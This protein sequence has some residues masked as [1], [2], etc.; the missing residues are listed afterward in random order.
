[1]Q[2]IIT[3]LMVATICISMVAA[4]LPLSTI[5]AAAS[6]EFTATYRSGDHVKLEWA[7]QMAD[8]DV[9]TQSGFE[10]QSEFSVYA[11]GNGTAGGQSQTNEDK[12]NGNYSLKIADTIGKGNAYWYPSTSADAS[13]VS[14]GKKYGIPRGTPLS[15][16]FK[17]KA[18]GTNGWIQPFMAGGPGK[19]SYP[20][21]HF[22]QYYPEIKSP[23]HF[24]A[25]VRAGDTSFT[26]DRIE[27]FNKEFLRR[28]AQGSLMTIADRSSTNYGMGATYIE[29]IDVANKRVYLYPNLPFRS[30]FSA[31][32]DV[33]SMYWEDN[34]FIGRT[35]T[36]NQGWRTYSTNVIVATNTDMEYETRG[37]DAIFDTIAPGTV[38]LDD[39]KFGYAQ[40]V[41]LYRDGQSLYKGYL[42]DYEDTAA[43]DHTAPP[44]PG[45]ASATPNRQTQ[46]LDLSWGIASD[47]GTT[48]TYRLKGYPRNDA[49]TALSV[50][51]PIT[52]TSGLKGYSIVV[53]TQ[54]N[55][56]PSG[57]ITT[58][59]NTWSTAMP[60]QRSF[61]HIAAVDQQGNVSPAVHLPIVDI[62]KP[63]ISVTP[64]TSEWTTGNIELHVS[65][66][67]ATT[68]VRQVSTPERSVAGSSASFTA[69][70]NGN[71]KFNAEDAFGNR[72]QAIYNVSY[73]DRQAPTVSF[74]PRLREWSADPIQVKVNINDIQSG[75]DPASIRYS[76]G[77]DANQDAA[78]R[79]WTTVTT[80]TFDVPIEA[81]GEWYLLVQA[82]D[83]VG[84]KVTASTDYLRLQK[85]P[86]QPVLQ[87]R[88]L[89]SEQISLD[90]EQPHKGLTDG[91]RYE[92]RN[93][94]TNQRYEVTY[95]TRNYVDHGLTPGTMQ[96]YRVRALNHAG[97]SEW[98][99][100][101]TLYTQPD[102]PGRIA[103]ELQGRNF[104]SAQ[105]T[106]QP[107]PSATAYHMTFTDMQ[108]GNMAVDQTIH[109]TVTQ[110]IYADVDQLAPNTLYDVAITAIN[111]AGEGMAKHTSYLSLP[112]APFGFQSVAA[113]E[114]SIDLKWS[115]VTG[116]VYGDLQRNGQSVTKDTYLPGD[117]EQ[118]SDTG[119]ASG[120]L[121]NY[122][123]S[124]ANTT[125]FGYFTYLPGIWT[126]PGKIES[127]HSGGTT[128]TSKTLQW[129][130]VQG[131]TAY[132][133]YLDGHYA[134]TVTGTTYTYLDL[135]PGQ[136][137]G[138]TVEAMN[139]SGTGTATTLIESTLPAKPSTVQ[140]THQTEYG[141]Q[142]QM[143][144]IYGA[145]RYRLELNGKVYDRADGK[146]VIEGLPAGGT[147][148]FNVQA[149][150]ESGYSKALSITTMT[151]PAAINEAKVHINEPGRI[152]IGWEP[153][154]G[155]TYYE[156]RDS[157]GNLEGIVS[158]AGYEVKLKPG[159]WGRVTITPVNDSGHGKPVTVDYRAVP[160]AGTIDPNQLVGVESRGTND[161][162]LRWNPVEGADEYRLYAPDG[163]K[164]A[165]VSGNTYLLL[166]GLDT[167]TAYSGYT[168]RAANSGGESRGYPVPSF[169]TRPASQFMVS[170]TANRHTANVKLTAPQGQER[171][172]ISSATG[173]LL[174]KGTEREWSIQSLRADTSYT[175][176]VW[177]ENEQGDRS[178]P[179]TVRVHT[180]R[181]GQIPGQLGWMSPPSAHGMNSGAS[182]D[183]SSEGELLVKSSQ[184]D[185]TI[186]TDPANT[187]VGRI[188][189]PV[190][191]SAQADFN[192]I[193]NHFAQLEINELALLGIV[194][195]KTPT[196]FAPNLGVTRA[197]F[198]SMLVR[199]VYASD[200]IQ[201]EA[202]E[203]TPALSFRDVHTQD[204]YV[205]ELKI[206]GQNG[207]ITGMSQSTFAPDQII[208]REQAA[209]ILAHALQTVKDEKAEKAEKIE[210]SQLNSKSTTLSSDS[211]TAN[212]TAKM[213]S[214]ATDIQTSV[215]AELAAEP[216]S[217]TD[218][219]YIA[220][221]AAISV[222][223]LTALHLMQGYPNG[224]FEPRKS[225][226]RAEAALMLYRSMSGL[227]YS[228]P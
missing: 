26:V 33:V 148:T 191:V 85:L 4:L 92:L 186:H 93:E 139:T 225:L 71:Y 184:N 196:T 228:H 121:F 185:Q 131:A 222:Q 198:M 62:D 50:E 48:Y 141:F 181:E 52:V 124:L 143:E 211:A 153:Q 18:L 110:A 201:A 114:H 193:H 23:V 87:A 227:L 144:P 216:V 177:S 126:L 132:R 107:V 16:T 111:P 30:N 3:K 208:T 83:R 224:A 174:F 14:L 11:G 147:Y 200:R 115:T 74:T 120:T 22:P 104:N 32:S 40:L 95:P 117:M 215:R 45:S 103:V 51:Q 37:M 56:Q 19:N 2:Q 31:G 100:P 133:L 58:T 210:A 77:S 207:W 13:R 91:L 34:A 166:S 79:T 217:Y 5:H 189:F 17:A 180:D 149:G 172:T 36:A 170:A 35:L 66:T 188:D 7:A 41:E 128:D 75:I 55:T 134:D 125:G 183:S 46:R 195:G 212:D 123:L 190:G 72:A 175:F 68:W 164:V 82:T 194:K 97:T 96:T 146:F 221:W 94:T 171:Y 135:E 202:A 140:V 15:I 155:A 163:S 53:D 98:S 9:I 142:V 86:E 109:S 27:E 10:N 223:E 162:L 145:D 137:Y 38:Y 12:S 159:Q 154:R 197:E 88:T 168:I 101:I 81:E 28:Q 136:M 161:V 204:W 178:A 156:V 176:L 151:I 187:T 203:S 213:E 220:D 39:F 73:I 158:E 206:A 152:V 130:S 59:A 122:E 102:I 167:A 226:N 214:V 70:A 165:T 106:I 150:N 112:A 179:V 57:Q 54:P 129:Q 67:D 169:M 192:D 219:D 108:S 24:S 21:N 43:I 127:L 84:N 89:S 209:K 173:K 138:F 205:P 8:A 90:W 64:S 160:D 6:P 1:M 78:H 218:R 20:L 199:L 80:S 69:T 60:A 49:A 63:E 116:A 119:L 42:S 61:V 76:L 157:Y 118:Y 113:Y 99:E 29:R 182:F 44:T 25:A 105:V 47:I 65:A